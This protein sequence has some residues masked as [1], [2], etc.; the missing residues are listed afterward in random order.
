M[1]IF[2]ESYAHLAHDSYQPKR[3]K[4]DVSGTPFEVYRIIDKPSGYHGVIY[5]NKV[6]NE[7][8]V[9]HR[10]TEFETDKVRDLAITDG[11]MVLVKL[12]Q[13]LNGARETVELALELARHGGL[14]GNRVPVTVTGHSLGGTL[15]Q[16]T[17]TEYGLHGETFNAYG[18]AGLHDTPSGGNQV[19]NHVR[20]T[21]MVSAA[22]QHF[23]SVRVY[24]TEQDV[25]LLLRDGTPP[26][27]QGVG[28][29]LRD[30]AELSPDKTHGMA[31]FYGQ[32][33]IVR[34]ENIALYEANKAGYDAYRTD[35]CAAAL[36]V[37]QVGHMPPASL[38]S[39]ALTAGFA[40]TKLVG[41]FDSNVETIRL[42]NEVIQ[43]RRAMHR[44]AFPGLGSPM[45]PLDSRNPYERFR[46]EL[47][48]P[49]HDPSFATHPDH[50]LL[51]QIRGQVRE[52]DHKYR[53]EFD[54]KSER[55]SHSLLVLANEK[56][57]ERVDHV[58]LS[59]S[60]TGGRVRP[61]ENIF[62]VQ[63]RLDNPA[64][65][66]ALMK[67]EAAAQTP[68]A[69][70]NRQLEILNQHLEDQQMQQQRDQAPRRET[71]APTM[72]L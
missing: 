29:F 46:D 39:G 30:V 25:A 1:A 7:L 37:R 64:H 11:Q 70:S 69:G 72:G 32:D 51:Q 47:D 6:T 54:E 20:A 43:E 27:T 66:R 38:I 9:A 55:M 63:G 44:D 24:A 5:R 4:D 49:K 50:A 23:G 35:I 42:R 3:V 22:G 17:A 36:T 10:G 41:T 62:I 28:Q 8:V 60:S 34:P 48:G 65:T 19:V 18:A 61:G 45:P 40:A 67:T 59:G 52:L 21:D 13:Q 15:A 71:Q 57:L 56:G 26:Q 68:I 53:R 58:V 31:Q 33:S 2:T 16:M 12:N 14:A